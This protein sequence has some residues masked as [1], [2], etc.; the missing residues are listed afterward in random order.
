MLSAKEIRETKSGHLYNLFLVIYHYPDHESLFLPFVFLMSFPLQVCQ[1]HL[2]GKGWTLRVSLIHQRS[3]S[4]PR[5]IER[6]TCLLPV[7][8]AARNI[9]QYVVNIHFSEKELNNHWGKL[10]WPKLVTRRLPKPSSWTP[11]QNS[12]EVWTN[13]CHHASRLQFFCSILQLIVPAPCSDR[14]TGM[15]TCEEVN[16]QNTVLSIP[17]GHP[18]LR[19][20]GIVR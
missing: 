12:V 5:S 17:E 4:K 6:L 16:L 20:S 18:F 9:F 8:F 3:T 7:L 15:S 13:K 2:H 19:A 11:L 14:I 1:H 10:L